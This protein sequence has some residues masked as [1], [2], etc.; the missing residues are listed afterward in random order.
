[1]QRRRDDGI[2]G[3]RLEA[4]EG[5]LGGLGDGEE[6][7]ELGE[8]E[9]GAEVLVEAGE[10]KLTTRFA[11]LLGDGDER[12]ESGRIDVAGAGEIDEDAALARIDRALHQLLQLLAIADDE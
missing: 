11:D 5:L 7:V 12:A 3:S 8:L 10:P 4:R 2:V 6:G 9:Q 1:T